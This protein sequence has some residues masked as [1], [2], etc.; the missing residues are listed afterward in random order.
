MR[1]TAPLVATDTRRIKSHDTDTRRIK[2]H[3]GVRVVSTSRQIDRTP[4][5]E[6]RRAPMPALA[7]DR[8][9]SA[10]T[11]MVAYKGNGKHDLA[12]EA[13]GKGAR[14]KVRLAE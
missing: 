5:F 8:P 2:S 1:T 9:R 10:S 6:T 13:R 7:D 4:Q 14:K 11:Q 12:Q 3:D